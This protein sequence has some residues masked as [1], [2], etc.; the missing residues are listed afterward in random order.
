MTESWT[1]EEKIP[2]KTAGGAKPAAPK[3]EKKA[4]APMDGEA[5]AAEEPKPA[6]PA[7]PEEQKYEIKQRKKERTTAVPFKTISHAIPPDQKVQFKGLE[8]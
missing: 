6:E 5:P 4:D 8:D 7:A 1:E 2:I 3:E